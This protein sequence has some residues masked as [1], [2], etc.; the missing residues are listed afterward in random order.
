MRECVSERLS[1]CVC[2]CVC[3][4]RDDKGRQGTKGDLRGHG[5]SVD[6]DRHGSVLHKDMWY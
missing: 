5:E 2:V 3:V 6:S 1:V 4:T